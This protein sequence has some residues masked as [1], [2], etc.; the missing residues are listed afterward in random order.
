[1]AHLSL[2]FFGPFQAALDEQPLTGFDSD[3][4]RALLAYLAVESDRAHRRESLSAMFWPER[5]ERTARHSLSQA[6]SNLRRLMDDDRTAPRHLETTHH[7]AQFDAGSDVR[8]DVAEFT[9]LIVACRRHDHVRLAL[10]APCLARVERAVALYQGDFLEGFSLTDASAF[11]EWVTLQQEHLRLLMIETLE[12]LAAAHEQRGAFEQGVRVARQAVAM[13][14]LR[15]SAQ[16]TLM[17]LLALA[18]ERSAA[19]RPV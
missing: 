15:E 14:P 19:H 11:S 4:G 8:L 5:P 2:S 9:D 18:G 6:L 13:D 17:R 1:M 16:R 10:C 3:K 7:T 12:E